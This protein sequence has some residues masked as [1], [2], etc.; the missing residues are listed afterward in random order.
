MD[1]PLT[2]KRNYGIDL[3]RLVAMFFVLILHTLGQGSL[4]YA[5]EFRSHQYLIAWFGEVAAY[6]GVDIFALISGY[7]AYSGRPKKY[8]FGRYIEL[9]LRVVFLGVLISAAAMLFFPET[10][11][12][13]TLVSSILPVSSGMYWYLTAYTGLFL[14]MP[15]LD[16]GL[17]AIPEKT[18]RKLFVVLFT[19]FSLY[20]AFAPDV[21][22]INKGYSFLW[23]AILYVMGAAIRKCGIGEDQRPLKLIAG[24]L[25]LY[26]FTWAWRVYGSDLTLIPGR[27]TLPE[28]FITTYSSP[29]VLAAAILY[30]I[31]FSKIKPGGAA[32]KII[33]FAS[34]CAFAA[35]IINTHPVIW[36]HFIRERFVP[37]AGRSCLVI[38][39]AVTGFS[40]AFLTASILIDKIRAWLFKILRVREL[41]DRMAAGLDRAVTAISGKL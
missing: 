7:V 26:L 4:L 39:L 27:L 37:F 14:I 41:A 15:L 19:A 28:E 23:I 20:D 22:H 18:A 30:V 29:T 36:N 21:F 8:S 33:A 24:I 31:L 32:E 1:T 9:W 12:V 38:V 40:L 17:R 3:L 34:P 5:T 16:A 6:C 35:Y 11:S 25:V 10:A 2:E 13:K